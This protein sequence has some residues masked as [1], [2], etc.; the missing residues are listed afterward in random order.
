MN[1]PRINKSTMASRA[2]TV[3]AIAPSIEER[4][5]QSEAMMQAHPIADRAPSSHAQGLQSVS[6][7]ARPRGSNGAY[8]IKAPLSLIDPG[9][10]NARFIYRP[11]R[12]AELVASIGRNGQETPG[13]ATIRDGRYILAAGHYRRLALIALRAETMDLMIHENVTD[14]QLYELSF[15]ENNEREGGSALDNALAWKKL[16][17][18]GV[19]AS[20]TDLAA[21]LGQSLPTVNKTLAILKLSDGIREIIAEDPTAFAMTTLYELSLYEPLGGFDNTR[22]L[23][24]AIAAG[25]AGRKEVQAARAKIQTPSARKPKELSRRYD[26]VGGQGITGALR[27]WDAAGKVTLDLVIENPLERAQFVEDIRK[28]F[29]AKAAEIEPE[30][31]PNSD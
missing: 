19:Y 9:H 5:R 8:L 30:S 21:Q 12:V 28:R 13:P 20:E 14:Q 29:G 15:R 2:L 24:M 17:S 31:K 16:L 26:L 4:I 1:A 22:A 6:S 27:E 25:E 3:G 7:E 23:V 11:K 18:D 10:Y